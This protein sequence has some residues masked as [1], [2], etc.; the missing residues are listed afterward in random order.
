MLLVLSVACAAAALRM[1]AGEF[2][3]SMFEALEAGEKSLIN[4]ALRRSNF[5]GE[6]VQ[7]ARDLIDRLRL[8]FQPR[9][10]FVF[11]RNVPD[12]SLDPNTGE[13]MFP[14]LAKSPMPQ[15]A[16]VFW[17]RPNGEKLVN[18]LVS[19]LSSYHRSFGF[20]KVWHLPVAY[21]GG[22]RKFDEPVT[23]FTNPQI[24]ATGTVAMLVVGDFFIGVFD[25][26]D[27]VV[28]D[29]QGRQAGFTENTGV[30]QDAPKAF[31]SG[32]GAVELLVVPAAGRRRALARGDR[33]AKSRL[34]RHR[35]QSC[36]ARA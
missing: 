29:A 33:A 2:L 25:P 35:S 30:V 24:P 31:L 14:V 28:T 4:D 16:W 18:S 20:Q 17:L 32:D 27:F 22:R 3:H 7:G 11:R 23:E 8:A 5:N 12:K 9:T 21:D 19:M 15:V 36:R 26:V 13:L 34:A 10:G 6:Q 1:P